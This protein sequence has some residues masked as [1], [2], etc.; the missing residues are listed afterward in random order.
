MTILALDLGG[1]KIAAALVADGRVLERRQVVTPPE[2]DIGALV[3]AADAAARPLLG[4]TSRIAVA[5][6]G[7]AKNGMLDAVNRAIFH[8]S[9][10]VPFA[11]MLEERLGRPATLLNDGAAAAWGEY[12]HGAGRGTKSLVFMTIST[13]IGGGIV[14]DGR[15][16]Q[17]RQ[18]LA[19]QL[20]F[21]TVE[22]DGPPCGSGRH[23]TLEAL[24]G[25][26]ALEFGGCVCLRPPDRE[27]RA[28]RACGCRR[29]AGQAGP[30]PSRRDDRQCH[31]RA[32]R[33]DRPRPDRDRRWHRPRR[34]L[35][36]ALEAQPREGARPVPGPTR[37]DRPRRRCRARRC[38]E[39]GRGGTW[40]SWQAGS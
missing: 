24:A 22:Q 33:P 11:S 36:C 10:P 37:R 20:G 15:L 8:L 30:G 18:G 13:G 25:G 6:A 28:V 19:G 31:C 29:R 1:S 12:R 5:T 21:M 2:P 38:R 26:R 35:S 9:A 40:L 34:G 7:L 27:P 4:D 3:E 39:L 23:G 14:V 16:L 32:R 17:G